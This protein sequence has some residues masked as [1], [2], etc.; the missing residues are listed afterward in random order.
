MKLLKGFLFIVLLF[1]ASYA[2]SIAIPPGTGTI[3]ISNNLS[4]GGNATADNVFIHSDLF[5]HSNTTQSVGNAGTWYNI[6]YNHDGAAK[7]G[8]THYY[9]NA[10]NDTFYPTDDGIY[11]IK[12]DGS[13]NSSAANPDDYAYMRIVVN[14]EEVRGSVGHAY[15]SKQYG[16]VRVVCGTHAE[17]SVGDE[18][19]IQFTGTDTAISLNPLSDA[20]TDHQDSSTV[21]FIRI[22]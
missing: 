16:Y 21:R 7:Q 22:R 14:G 9:S 10:S 3:G 15:L 8:I 13:F 17:L 2:A 4:V 5:S 19:K 1:G 11:F 12:A 6:T 20:Y 18:V